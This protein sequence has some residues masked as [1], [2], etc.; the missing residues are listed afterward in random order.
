MKF[1]SVMKSINNIII[2]R[3]CIYNPS[4]SQPFN[5][6]KVQLVL[7]EGNFNFILEKDH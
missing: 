7:F 4:L 2:A 1:K 3:F 5:A 6:K